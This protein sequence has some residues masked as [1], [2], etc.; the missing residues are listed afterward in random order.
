[1]MPTNLTKSRDRVL[2]RVSKHEGRHD[3]LNLNYDG[4]GLSFGIIQWAQKPG[5]LG[6]LLA[7]GRGINL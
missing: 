4:A 2:A 5:S 6:V 3:S 7:E 1:M